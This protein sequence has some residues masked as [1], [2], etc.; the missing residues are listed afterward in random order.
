MPERS[1]KIA[2][3]IP[4]Y[5]E[6]D[7]I[8]RII[9]EMLSVLRSLG[10]SPEIVVVDDNSPDGTASLV[11]SLQSKEENIILLKRPGK[12]GLGSAYVEGY[13]RALNERVNCIIQMDADLSHPTNTAP[14]LLAAIE[15]GYDLAIASRY[16]HGGGIKSWTWE[17][18][19]MSKAAN[20]LVRVLLRTGLRDNT[21]GYRAM[22]AASVK[23]LMQYEIKSSGFSYLVEAAVVLSRMKLKI[24]EIPFTYE[25]REIGETKLSFIEII[26][27]LATVGRLLV[28][29]TRKKTILSGGTLGRAAEK[30]QI[31]PTR[32]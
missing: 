26:R 13:K 10:K 24:K 27:F 30:I 12:L 7:N 8:G 20:Y 19:I 29:G 6:K 32:L 28:F 25:G 15:E 9:S 31:V 22:R 4:T 17:R 21:S 16:I 11:Q 5:N 18:R 14:D 3:I 1:E 23:E 2:V